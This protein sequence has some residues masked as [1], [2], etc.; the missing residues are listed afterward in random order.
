MALNGTDVSAFQPADIENLIP[1]DF[2]IVKATEGTSYVSSVCDAQ[3][4][5]LYKSGKSSGVYHFADGKDANAEADWFVKNIKGYIGKSILILDL[6]A[7]ALKLGAPWALQVLNR[8]KSTTGV[9]PLLYGSRGNIC[10][11]AYAQIA[12]AGFPLYV[13]AYPSPAPAGYGTYEPGSVSPWA[14][15]TIFQYSSS[16][17]L[18]GYAGALD[19]DI[20]FITAEQWA[21]LA[22]VGGTAVTPS[23]PVAPAPSASNVVEQEQNFLNAARGEKL[24]V[25]GVVGPATKAAIERYQTFL[26]AYGYTG[27]IDGVWGAGTQAA[28]AKYYAVWAAPKAPATRATISSGSTGQNV[29]DVQSTL[30]KNYPAYSHLTVDGIFG[31]ATLAV[32]KEFQQRAGLVVDGIV[33]PATYAKL[34]L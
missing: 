14:A 5:A 33:G 24:V 23:S 12:Q 13:A 26:R 19:L 1:H 11:P 15:A 18:A 27:A 8:I 32:V 16:G 31:P 2:G 7:G 30:N 29:K 6:E 28:H 17:H 4:Q 3:M 22:K 34:G 9:N 20:A 10:L 21:E 25:D